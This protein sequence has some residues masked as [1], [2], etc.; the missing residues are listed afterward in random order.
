MRIELIH[1]AD[2]GMLVVS[3][4]NVESDAQWMGLSKPK[5]PTRVGAQHN[6]LIHLNLNLKPKDKML[7][8]TLKLLNAPDF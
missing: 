8:S 3:H 4:M 1:S 5:T 7:P 2:Y 6:G